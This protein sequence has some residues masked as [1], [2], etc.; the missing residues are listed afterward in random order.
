MLRTS[1]LFASP[2]PG[3]KITFRWIVHSFLQSFHWLKKQVTT[4]TIL[5]VY[6]TW[7]RLKRTCMKQKKAIE[8]A[9]DF[10]TEW[11]QKWKVELLNSKTLC[12]GT[13]K[14]LFHRFFEWVH[15]CRNFALQL[16]FCTNS[17]LN[18][19]RLRVVIFPKH[20]KLKWKM[21]WNLYK[22]KKEQ[23]FCI[24]L[25]VFL[26]LKIGSQVEGK[27]EENSLDL[28]MPCTELSFRIEI[29]LW[30][31]K[32]DSSPREAGKVW[33]VLFLSTSFTIPTFLISA[34]TSVTTVFSY[35]CDLH[36]ERFSASVPDSNI[37][38]P[39]SLHLTM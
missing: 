14:Q 15:I 37:A 6:W 38:V 8:C 24:F 35:T 36:P 7:N 26:F 20:K 3:L 16:T 12:W 39:F 5:I 9:D 21:S 4:Y 11:L 29:L 31:I 22:R 19:N 33:C 30:K 10:C 2:S 17:K 34:L 32:E 13:L 27:E 18:R 28:L 1:A 25:N 23:G